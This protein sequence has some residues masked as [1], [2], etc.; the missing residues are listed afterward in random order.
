MTVA[1]VVAVV[2]TYD[3]PAAML[4]ACLGAVQRQTTRVTRIVLVDNNRD[5]TVS[6]DAELARVAPITVESLGSNEGPAGGFAHG[7]ALCLGSRD[8]AFAWVLDDDVIADPD[9]LE[10]LLA[11]MAEQQGRAVIFPQQT[12]ALT[13]D[14]TD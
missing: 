2:V 10:H 11:E 12:N 8:C 3:A 9:C 6:L 1:S 13:G 7:L 4:H 14:P 5:R